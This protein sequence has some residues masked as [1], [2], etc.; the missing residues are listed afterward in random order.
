[1]VKHLFGGAS[2][3]LDEIEPR[4]EARTVAEEDDGSGL[5]MGATHRVPDSRDQRVVDGVALGRTIKSDPGNLAMRLIG[6]ELTH[7][8]DALILRDARRSIAPANT[9]S[10]ANVYA[11]QETVRFNTP[12]TIDTG[13]GPGTCRPKAGGEPPG[14]L[15]WPA[16]IVGDWLGS[17]PLMNLLICGSRQVET[18]CPQHSADHGYP[19][20]N[21]GEVEIRFC[22]VFF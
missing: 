14:N 11:R 12:Q 3:M 7:D 1:V 21:G 16:S 9:G 13:F 10:H 2:L 6:Q 20:V 22:F 19:I 18:L 4:A 5:A 8:P 17:E 15:H